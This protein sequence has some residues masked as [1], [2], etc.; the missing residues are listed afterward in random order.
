MERLKQREALS[1]TRGRDLQNE[2]GDG[3]L[4]GR[5]GGLN[6]DQGLLFWLDL[7]LGESW[8]DF[9]FV[10]THSLHERLATAKLGLGRE[11]ERLCR[12]AHEALGA[13]C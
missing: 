6:E 13:G 7:L 3:R 8:M 11:G 9:C 4:L 12:C 2:P 1:I 5:A 10:P